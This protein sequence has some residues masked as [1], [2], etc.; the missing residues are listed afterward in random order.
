MLFIQQMCQMFLHLKLQHGLS[1]VGLKHE[2]KSSYSRVGI[3]RLLSV[4]L[5][6]RKNSR[7]EKKD[8]ERMSRKEQRFTHFLRDL[9]RFVSAYIKGSQ[10]LAD[11]FLDEVVCDAS[12]GV[13]VENR[14]H[15][16]DLGCAASR[17][18]LGGTELPDGNTS[19]I[20]SFN[21]DVARVTN[22]QPSLLWKQVV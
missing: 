10:G 2:A 3:I 15:Q 12:R 17:F 4:S 13:L 7:L 9:L 16:S 5:Q 22:T 8:K 11:A 1:F 18:S 19:I 14:V 20:W 6:R 21:R